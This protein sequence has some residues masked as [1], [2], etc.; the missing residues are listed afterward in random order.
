MTGDHQYIHVSPER[1]AKKFGGPTVY[2][3]LSLS[4]IPHLMMEALVDQ[5]G[6]STVLNYGVNR[7]RFILPIRPCN[8]IRLN[9]NI[10]CT[11]QKKWPV[12]D[13]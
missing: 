7:L 13:C 10:A 2:G 12:A 6:P 3:F 8:F 5:I 11:E 1:A 4:L 9:W